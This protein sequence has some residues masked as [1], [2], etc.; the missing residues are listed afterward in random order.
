MSRKL[1]EPE[2]QPLLEDPLLTS[3][4]EGWGPEC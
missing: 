4:P 2:Q 1:A 3:P